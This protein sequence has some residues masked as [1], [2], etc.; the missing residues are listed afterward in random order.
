MNNEVDS[1]DI[2][3]LDLPHSQI[4]IKNGYIMIPEKYRD[5]FINHFEDLDDII[6]FKATPENWR[7]LHAIYI[8]SFWLDK[9]Y[10]DDEDLQTPKTKFFIIREEHSSEHSSEDEEKCN[11]PIV[12]KKYK[13]FVRLNSVSCKSQQPFNSLKDALKSIDQ[14]ERCK[15]A[16][17][18]AKLAGEETIIS[19][20]EFKDLSKGKEYRC[21]IF[22]DRLRKIVP[23]DDKIG[24]LTCKQLKKRCQKLLLLF[25]I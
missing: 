17:E 23:N 10:V 8:S 6:K 7:I 2:K 15:K 5:L 24:N 20:R 14:S 1:T 22:E 19:L 21:V 12:L 18:I 11:S 4:K 25:Y 16:I 3:V 9:W 13:Q